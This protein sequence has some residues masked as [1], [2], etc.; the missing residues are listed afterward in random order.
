MRLSRVLA[1]AVLAACIPLTAFAD[2]ATFGNNDGVFSATGSTSPLTLSGSFL[3]Q[4]TGLSPLIPD[5]S[6]VF[7]TGINNCVPAGCLGSVTLTTGAYLSGTPLI[8]LTGGPT[9]TVNSM[10]GPGGTFSVTGSGFVFTGTFSGAA[11]TCTT[12]PCNGTA[13]GQWDLVAQLAGGTLQVG[14]AMYTILPGGTI[15]LT[16]VGKPIV[17]RT[18]GTITGITWKDNS[19]TTTFPS[20]VP[21]PGTL[22]LLGGGLI[23]IGLLAK[24]Q[25]RG[26]EKATVC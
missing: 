17:T 6:S 10:F 7:N 14:S 20:P 18:G 2:S 8:N 12:A 25:R 19:G 21:E 22:T 9:G 3:T 26:S 16:A 15:Q 4:I 1:L 24:R 5:Q 11:W 13:A 23:G